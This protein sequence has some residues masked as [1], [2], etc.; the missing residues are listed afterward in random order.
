[1]NFTIKISDAEYV[2]LISNSSTKSA[3]DCNFSCIPYDECY[4][5][6]GDEKI[7]YRMHVLV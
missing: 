7:L 3:L 6:V 2:P 4:I 5:S 1:M